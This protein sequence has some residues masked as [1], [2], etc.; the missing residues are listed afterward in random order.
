MAKEIE[1][2]METTIDKNDIKGK[3]KKTS[4]QKASKI[5]VKDAKVWYDDFN[6]I[7]GI[8]MQIKP[9]TITAF[10]GP[11]VVENPHF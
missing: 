1:I 2:I 3:A 9:K 6:A 8:N 11:S 10:I 4:V 5:E 7:K